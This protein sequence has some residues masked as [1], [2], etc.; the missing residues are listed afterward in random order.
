[1][2]GIF[3]IV[4]KTSL[5]FYVKE[6][7]LFI[8]S[9]ILMILQVY[10]TTSLSVAQLYRR[11]TGSGAVWSAVYRQ[12]YV[13]ATVLSDLKICFHDPDT[14]FLLR[15]FEFFS[16]L[17]PSFFFIWGQ[18]RTYDLIAVALFS[19]A[20]CKYRGHLVNCLPLFLV[21]YCKPVVCPVVWKVHRYFM[22]LYSEKCS[23]HSEVSSAD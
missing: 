11:C 8:L 19:F 14:L 10:T 5:N 13:I 17:D 22:L 20:V 2:S 6:P 23:V 1:M 3:V 7:F 18:G 15:T 12:G 4:L 16:P 9:V 21:A